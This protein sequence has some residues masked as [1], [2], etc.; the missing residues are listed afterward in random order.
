MGLLSRMGLAEEKKYFV[1][2]LSMLL[3]SGMSI[4]AAL[5]AIRVELKSVQMKRMVRGLEEDINSGANLSK[6]LGSTNLFSPYVISLIEIGEQSGRLSENLEVINIQQQKENA[7]RSKVKSATLYP[8]FV[9]VFTFIVAVFLSWFVLPKLS[10]VF[11]SLNVE[12]PWITRAIISTGN[13]VSANGLNFI[14][15]VIVLLLVLLY[16]IFIFRKTKFIGEAFLFTVPVVKDFI[17]QVQLTRFGFILGSLL[18]S[19]LPVNDALDSL[20][21]STSNKK[22]KEFYI[23]LRKSI[24][25]GNS[26]QKSFKEYPKMRKLIPMPIQQIIVAGEQSGGLSATL[27]KVAENYESKMD[28][29]TKNLAVMLEPILLILVGLGV[30]IIAIGVILPIY[31]LLDN[32]NNPNNSAPASSAPA[33]IEEQVA[34]PDEV[35]IDQKLFLE[36]I[37]DSSDSVDVYDEPDGIVVG[38][39]AMGGNFE[40]LEQE[41]DWTKISLPDEEIIWIP[42]QYVKIK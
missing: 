39:L 25:D 10:N 33:R 13:F 20:I 2:N 30:A 24:D 34:I 29:T 23:Y 18:E 16:F 41:D 37:S 28:N 42:S 17:R 14:P 40:L 9:L 27:T 31:S 11:S 7:I 19:G 12:L 21:S 26:F 4:L 5:K 38:Q 6:A 36:I 1:E 3:A 22:Y 8:V 32:V 35:V 15:I